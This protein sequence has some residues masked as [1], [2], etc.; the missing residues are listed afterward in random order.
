VEDLRAMASGR[1]DPARQARSRAGRTGS[2][3]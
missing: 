1:G 3:A 2:W